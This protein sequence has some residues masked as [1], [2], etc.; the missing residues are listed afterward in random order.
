M[1]I[2]GINDTGNKLITGVNNTGDIDKIPTMNLLP[3]TLIPVNR[4]CEVSL[5][6]S[7]NGGSNET[8]GSCV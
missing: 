4:L 2:T 1:Y 8:I 6:V 3:V 5:D 7:F